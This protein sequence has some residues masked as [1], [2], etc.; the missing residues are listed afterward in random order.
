[1][2][3]CFGVSVLSIP[4]SKR[5][6]NV[7]DVRLSSGSTVHRHGFKMTKASEPRQNISTLPSRRA[8]LTLLA[9]PLILPGS[10]LSVSASDQTY[11]PI[12]SRRYIDA[13]RPKPD[14]EPPKFVSSIPVF[15]I[16]KDLHA[17]DISSGTGDSISSGALVRAHWIMRLADGTTVDDSSMSQPALFRPGT[18]Q[19]PPGIEDAIIGMRTNGERRVSGSAE[20]I[21]T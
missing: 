8:F 11:D 17:Q 5:L 16:D 20:R 4:D 13:G 14:A 10:S 15:D 12:K 21:L 18:H 6:L 3:I 1:M 2:V 7:K 19:V 9:I